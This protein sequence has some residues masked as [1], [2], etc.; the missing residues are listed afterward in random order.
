[1]FTEMN[2]ARQGIV[3]IIFLGGKAWEI[4]ISID[5]SLLTTKDGVKNVQTELDKLLE[6][7][8]SYQM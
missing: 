8:K 6:N 2:K 4:T 3:L 1:M 7:E 5:K